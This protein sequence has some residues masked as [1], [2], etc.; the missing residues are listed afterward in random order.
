MSTLNKSSAGSKQ[1]QLY[2][3]CYCSEPSVY[4]EN[5]K[6]KTASLNVDW[7]IQYWFYDPTITND[8]GKPKPKL[9]IVK[10]MNEYKSLPLRRDAVKTLLAVEM[11]L[12][13]V[14]GFN[15]I[16]KQFMAPIDGDT[17][18]QVSPD[19]SFYEALEQSF[20]L[21]ECGHDTK[22]DIK[23]NL[24]YIKIA[25]SQLRFQFLAIKDVRQKHIYALLKRLAVIKPTL[26]IVV[27]NRKGEKK[28]VGKGRWTN[29]TFNA[30]R[31][32]LSI[33]F[34]ELIQLEATEVNPVH[35]LKK[36]KHA[37]QKKEVLT[38]DE[39][40]RVDE[41]AM[42]Y[43]PRFWMLIHIFYHSGART[44]EIFRVRGEH[45]NLQKQVVKY[46]ILKGQ[47]EEWIERPIVDEA[48]PFWQ[49]AMEGCRKKDY[50]FSVGLAPGEKPI[51]PKQ[52]GRRWNRHINKKL[53]IATSW[54]GLK[55]LNVTENI[56]TVFAQIREAQQAATEITGHKS[57]VMV[58]KI[59]DIKS[60][61]RM[62]DAI[63]KG[64]KKF[65]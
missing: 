14:Q 43:D 34:E 40:R 12:L 21:L 45:V 19:T 60:A 53:N 11:D 39:C 5:W 50:V 31:K 37:P 16:T 3:G 18:H 8:K 58:A 22:L 32:N 36:K 35:G 59:Y 23:S 61:Q 4:P 42:K 15:P 2:G 64:S 6:E 51:S 1:I 27:T 24:H 49:M 55:Y 47:N 62:G 33:L 29:N 46:L 30:Y 13:K 63:K 65:G 20:Q 57:S 38:P 48:L 44:T 17:V 25:S 52:A 26:D 54:Y 56:D 41:F 10:G 28:V 9:R 7:Y